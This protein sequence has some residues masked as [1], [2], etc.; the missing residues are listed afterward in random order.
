MTARTLPS[1]TPS[2]IAVEIAKTEL[3]EGFDRILASRE[4]GRVFGELI[5]QCLWAIKTQSQTNRIVLARLIGQSLDRYSENNR[6]NK[7]SG[8]AQ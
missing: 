4:L 5:L 2:R 6:Q 1:K 3:H 8:G 7:L